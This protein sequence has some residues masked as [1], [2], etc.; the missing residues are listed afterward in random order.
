MH[1]QIELL[2][3]A[4][5]YEAFLAAVENGANA[6]YLGGKQLNARQSAGNF[7]EQELEKAIDYAHLRGVAVYLTMNTLVLD[8]ELEQAIEFAK[9]AY[10]LGIDAII[11][12]D[13]GFAA[14]IR[15]QLPEVHLHASTQMTTYSL[16]GVKE[17]EQLGFSRVVLAR[18][19]S[20]S[21]IEYI[22]K[23]TKL[24]I[25]AFVHGALC[26]SYSGQCLMS[27]II[28]GRSGNRGKCA[29]PCRLPYTMLREGNAVGEGYL[30]SPKD[31]SYIED[32]DRLVKA[33][34]H[35]FKIEGRMKSPEYVA[36]VV[37][38]YRKYLDEVIRNINS[39]AQANALNS[40]QAN[41]DT[42]AQTNALNSEQASADT[43]A[44]TS[45]DTSSD[46]SADK[47]TGTSAQTSAQTNADTSA[48]TRADA[49]SARAHI[50]EQDMHELMQSFNRGGF[51]K[52]YLNKKTGPDMM[53]YK[54]PK[55][56]GTYLGV[57]AAHNEKTGSLRI[58]LDSSLNMGD[59]IEVWTNSIGAESPGGIVTKIIKDKQ[60]V[61]NAQAGDTVTVEIIR[62]KIRSGSKI[63]KTT[64][65]ALNEQANRSYTSEASRKLPICGE[66]YMQKGELPRLILR[67]HRGNEVLKYG[68]VVAEIAQNKPLSEQR[69]R[70]QLC[71]MGSTPF[72][73]ENLRINI[74]DGL[75]L[76]ISELNN[77]RR[78]AAQELEELIVSSYKRQVQSGYIK[79]DRINNTECITR[80]IADTNK[81][82]VSAEPFLQA[83][84]L[85]SA[86][87][88]K[89][90][91]PLLS[92]QPI[93][94]AKPLLSAIFYS[95]SRGVE[96]SKLDVDR[97]Y[98]P[99]NQLLSKDRQKDIEEA[100]SMGKEI[101]SAIPAITRGKWNELVKNNIVK[102][103]PIIDGFLCGSMSTI[104]ILKQYQ[105]VE[106]TKVFG[107]YS[108]NV[109]NGRTLEQLKKLGLS[110]AMLSYELN[111]RNIEQLD[112]PDG[113]LVEAGV[114]GKLPVMTSEYCPIGSVCAGRSPEGCNAI[115]RGGTYHL[116]DRMGARFPV[117]GDPIDCRSTIYNAN[118]LFA[119]EAIS[120]LAKG[121]IDYLRLSFVDES[122]EEIYNIINVHRQ[123]INKEQADTDIIE[124]IRARGTTK[125]HFNRGV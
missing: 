39:D 74:D 66:F 68:E 96:L 87:P 58:K 15:E 82:V 21:E 115:C 114:Y 25:E 33:G 112:I 60:L 54:K 59:G 113:F 119:P 48:E 64:D 91:K 51:S 13:L 101:Y 124:E 75:V 37:S 11:V 108:L 43:S 55:N 18:E 2:A 120:K 27:S 19:L 8:S 85:L 12:Q 109:L 31:I 56:W 79:A 121:N 94:Q 1:R 83:K 29:Q 45:A 110:G 88:I 36:M 84:P 103:E 17:L 9:V 80:S 46:T 52:G 76:P 62:G 92:A 78:L 89:Q 98:I 105:T 47:S 26:I 118:T 57:V 4:G 14:A 30:L 49:R 28:G 107:D 116:K 72:F 73:V 53:T 22:C 117:T 86:Q 100:R 125:G 104:N 10:S 3:P 44:E 81:Q 50:S 38:K 93:K 32:L 95:E 77:I 40:E 67:D 42:S 41:A 102:I 111:L 34:V 35:S 123:L 6:V 23:N 90:A 24:E 106:S 71:K 65:K 122:A 69:I 99:F 5:S 97:L 20:L 70:E 61:R 16:E 7:D 63:Y